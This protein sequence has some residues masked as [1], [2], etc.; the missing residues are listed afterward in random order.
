MGYKIAKINFELKIW[1]FYFLLME[2][3]NKND[4]NKEKL[5][6]S[7]QENLIKSE[8]NDYINDIIIKHFNSFEKKYFTF[9]INNLFFSSKN[10]KLILNELILSKIEINNI[11]NNKNNINIINTNN[12][13]EYGNKNII[14]INKLN[15][16]LE[17]KKYL[18][19]NI[20]FEITPNLIYFI[21]ILTELFGK[22]KNPK[23]KKPK[24][25]KK[26]ND[27][28]DL[29]G[30]FLDNQD[31]V[32]II[33]TNENIINKEKKEF[34][35]NG[36]NLNIKIYINNNKEEEN[37]GKD[38]FINDIFIKKDKYDYIDFIIT[39]LNNNKQ[40]NSFSYE[41]INISYIDKENKK[42]SLL[43][44][45][46][47]E[48]ILE[49]KKLI[50]INNQ[51]ELIMD[52][53]IKILI[54]FNPK[55]INNILN[56]VNFVSQLLEK[57]GIKNINNNDNKTGKINNI[58]NLNNI[59]NINNIENSNIDSNNK[60][61][62]NIIDNLER[63][64]NIDNLNK[65][66]VLDELFKNNI[67]IK[68]KKIKIFII[69]EKKDY[70]NIENSCNDLHLENKNNVNIKNNDF[71]CIKLNDIGLNLKKDINNIMKCNLYLKSFII[72]DN[73][74]KSIY[75]ILLSN[76]YFKNKEQCFIN[77][78]F[79]IKKIENNKY[80]KYEIKPSIKIS[81]ISIYLDQVSLYYL[82]NS[83]NQIKNKK[84]NIEKEKE[85][86]IKKEEEKEN[87]PIKDNDKYIINNTNI[88]IFFIQ[89]NYN[90]N[91]NV[92]NKNFL[93][94]RIIRIIN[95]ISLV[96]LNIDFKEYKNENNKLNIQQVKLI[97]YKTVYE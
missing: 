85:N 77:C 45:L 46:K 19:E 30:N 3:N 40:E 11:N 71:I 12:K 67:N 38:L 63:T 57:K 64:N 9:F 17:S 48:N 23:T 76:Y 37:F 59:N 73:I 26:S 25:N 65:I 79:E 49:N 36:K 1:L 28:E 8:E 14:N 41:K 78:D 54:F 13:V 52:L 32:N 90:S 7:H 18:Y 35:I 31:N 69:N 24:D 2:N 93:D 61:N 82:Y 47:S 89:I 6:I 4:N 68:V 53:K 58:N 72:K 81:P 29:F 5:W 91:N 50:I 62:I 27:N 51:N 96:N 15:L 44:I 34:I 42:Y 10:K 56:Y 22:N 55:I 80:D 21:K 83:F 88:D 43:N 74:S 94:S 39:N 87:I 75:K 33:N 95:S 20:Y 84:E 92:D 86:I 66:F 16:D 70:L 60:E 97:T